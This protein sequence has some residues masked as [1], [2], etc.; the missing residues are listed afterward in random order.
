MLFCILRYL[1]EEVASTPRK[2]L[3]NDNNR[4]SL[5]A[6]SW[7]SIYTRERTRV[8]ES[9]CDNFGLTVFQKSR[10]ASSQA[11]ITKY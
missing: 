11:G 8:G 4:P 6:D 1:L 7:H 9:H 3:I 2:E 10:T 5:T